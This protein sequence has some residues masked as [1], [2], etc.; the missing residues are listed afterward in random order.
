MKLWLVDNFKGEAYI[1]SA[2][3][4]LEAKLALIEQAT[5]AINTPLHVDDLSEFFASEIENLNN[6]VIAKVNN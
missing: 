5:T 4:E 6:V 3:S 2:E 1:V